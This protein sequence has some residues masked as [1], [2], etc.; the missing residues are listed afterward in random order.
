[1]SSQPEKRSAIGWACLGAGVALCLGVVGPWVRVWLVQI[2]G[3]DVDGGFIVLCCAICLVAM[4]LVYERERKS[5]PCILAIVSAS[6]ALL[7]LLAFTASV[8][9]ESSS[10]DKVFGVEASDLVAPAW[11]LYLSYCAALTGLGTSIALLVEQRRHRRTAGGYM[12][13]PAPP[14]Q[15]FQAPAYAAPTSYAPAGWYRRADGGWGW[16]DG[17]RWTELLP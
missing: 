14:V 11:G 17:Y 1:M 8:F 2:G 5:W 16:W 7:Y 4:P 15:H 3:L 10:E 12:G 6:I 13:Q 9:G